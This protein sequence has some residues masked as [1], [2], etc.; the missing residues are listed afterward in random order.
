MSEK[1]CKLCGAPV[2]R[3]VKYKQEWWDWCSNRCMGADPLVLEKKKQ[4]MLV[5]FGVDHPMHSDVFRD[6]QK[7]TLIDHYGVDN[8][9]KSDEVKAIMKV[10]FI[11]K[12]GVDNPSKDSAVIEQIRAKAVSR[13]E[14]NKDEILS[15]RRATSLH[16][17][18]VT[19][20]KYKHITPESLALMNDLEWLKNQHFDQKK[21]FNE[22]AQELG[23]SATPI[24][25]RFMLAGLKPT[26]F[27]TSLVER[28]IL[29]FIRANYTGEIRTTDRT[30]IAPHELDI[31]L[32][33]LGLAIEVNGVFW[34]SQE[35]GKGRGYHLG[36][37]N[38][39]ESHGIHVLHIYD[40][41][42]EDIDKKNIIKSK[43]LHLFG[44]SQRQYARRCEVVEISG[45]DTANFLTANHLQGNCPAKYRFGLL[46]DGKLQAVATFGKSRYNKQYQWELLRYCCLTGTTVVGGL[47]KIMKHAA[48]QLDIQTLISYADRRWSANLSENVYEKTGFAY[49][50]TAA[51]NYKYFQINSSKIVLLSRNQFQKHML[52]S[53]LEKYD[54]L[55]TEYENM[56]LNRY[57]RIWDCGNL[58]YTWKSQV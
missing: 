41:E 57:F 19:S 44:K 37:T 21:S 2:T 25:H 3:F 24:L 46:L 53:K 34:H 15:K 55:L 5:K 45:S 38:Q 7:Q 29:E 12:Y 4:T 14:T 28:E 54:E 40:T 52:E 39:C 6:K 18:G 13:Y 56:S 33:A 9:F 42:W 36:K 17:F 8:P 11:Q 26:R 49:L 51:P 50:Q 20:N 32:P 16:T 48:A 47:S 31:Y 23:I 30:V 1:L 43:L 22:I 10:T 58:V 27:N 35:R